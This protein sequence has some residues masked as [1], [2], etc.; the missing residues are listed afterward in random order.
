MLE[1]RHDQAVSLLT[2]SPNGEAHLVVQ[3]EWP[4]AT[5]TPTATLTSPLNVQTPD[6]KRDQPASGVSPPLA[7]S[8][9]VVQTRLP[10]QGST[11]YGAGYLTP[12]V[13]VGGV[14]VTEEV[15][16]V[17]GQGPLGLSIVGGS[18]H[19][20]HPFGINEPGVFISKVR[21]LELS[22]YA[23]LGLLHPHMLILTL[24]RLSV[25]ERRPEVAN[26]A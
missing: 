9:P 20:S 6:L 17:K 7:Q 1:A 12:S 3:R 11:G 2:G 14:L 24:C 21:H 19:S 5:S 8:S 22:V 26:S 23:F 10:S 4:L 15:R 18:D 13:P 25:T 16:L